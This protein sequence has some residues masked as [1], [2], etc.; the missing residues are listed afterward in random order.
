M[1]EFVFCIKIYQSKS[2]K[3]LTNKQIGKKVA[4]EMQ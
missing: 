2:N 1:D 3:K 4:M